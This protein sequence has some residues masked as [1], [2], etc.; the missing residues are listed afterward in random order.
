M[1]A[2]LRLAALVDPA[3]NVIAKLLKDVK[4]DPKTAGRTAFGVLAAN[5]YGPTSKIIGGG[6]DGALDVNVNVSA[7]EDLE[8]R[9]NSL[10]A[11]TDAPAVLSEPN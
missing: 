1:A 11:G 4:K 2:K 7:K 9:I 6:V 10:I 8:S 3:I 5:G